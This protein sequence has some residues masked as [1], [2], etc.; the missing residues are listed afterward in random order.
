MSTVTDPA[1]DAVVERFAP[2]SGRFSGI[3]GLITAA[4]VLILAVLGWDAGTPLGVAIVAL[5]GGLMVWAA[6][7]RPA[8]WTT[9]D[10]LVMRGMFG[11]HLVPLAAIDTVIVTQVLAVKV[12]DKRFVSPVIGY[13][14]RQTMKSKVRDA[15]SPSSS[16]PAPT[17]E[18]QAFVEARIAYVAQ[19]ARD[20]LGIRKGSPE[21]QALAA[22]VRHTWAWPELVA[23]AVLVLAFVV[24]VIL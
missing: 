8:L 15:R 21:Q 16:A 2:T 19:D 7:L 4:V 20:R 9:S 10:D 3:A 22:G 6:M 1:P 14:V 11:S 23:A 5:F 13:T 18:H 24:W 12:G 17:Q